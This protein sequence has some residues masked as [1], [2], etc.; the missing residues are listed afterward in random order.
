MTPYYN[1][2]GIFMSGKKVFTHT[3]TKDGIIYQ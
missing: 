1:N 2:K 3:L